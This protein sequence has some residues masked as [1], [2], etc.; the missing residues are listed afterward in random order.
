MGGNVFQCDNGVLINVQF[1]CDGTNDCRE[2]NSSD[3][4]HCICTGE[5]Y[6]SKRCKFIDDK[7]KDLP[8]SC[9]YYYFMSHERNC[10]KYLFHSYQQLLKNHVEHQSSHNKPNSPFTLRKNHLKCTPENTTNMYNISNICS[11]EIDKNRNYQQFPCPHGEHL[12]NCKEFEC[13][14]KFKCQEFYCI[15][16]TY[17]C[18]GK[19]DC[20][21]GFDEHHCTSDKT[22]TNMFKCKHSLLCIHLGSVCDDIIDCPSNDDEFLCQLHGIACPTFCECLAFAIHCENL[23]YWSIIQNTNK[24]SFHVIHIAFS[25]ELA[26]KMFLQRVAFVTFIKLIGIKLKTICYIFPYTN[27]TLV[28]D[29]GFNI[30]RYLKYFCFAG[31]HNLKILKL[32]NN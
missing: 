7:E 26:T 31:L 3:E 10:Q 20:P 8:K 30:L 15:P 1:L 6:Y 9:S 13:N 16:W 25:Q 11:Y 28:I 5:Q 29:A 22:C 21:R 27:D 19:W 4:T 2:N 12:Q 17:V 18:D 24:Y 23:N 14:M 32:N